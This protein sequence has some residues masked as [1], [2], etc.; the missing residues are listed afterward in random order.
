[1]RKVVRRS[2][3]RKIQTPRSKKTRDYRSGNDF[4][5]M[6]GPRYTRKEKYVTEY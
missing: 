3:T 2:Q 1:M 5:T 4:P 6:K